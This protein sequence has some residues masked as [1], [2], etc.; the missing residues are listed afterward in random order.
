MLPAKVSMLSIARARL[1]AASAEL[2]ISRS[3]FL[4]FS[5]LSIT[6]MRSASSATRA[7]TSGASLMILS[8]GE[9]TDGITA[10][11]RPGRGRSGSAACVPP[12]S[13]M[14]ESP[15]MPCGC[16]PATVSVRTGV[17][18]RSASVTWMSSRFWSSIA[19]SDTVPT[20]T[21]R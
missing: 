6:V 17:S 2:S 18:G 8:S 21:P 11:R 16:R 5:S 1:A 20:G 4:A 12:E 9:G 7:T 15:V 3:M 10:R 14:N 13:W 19:M